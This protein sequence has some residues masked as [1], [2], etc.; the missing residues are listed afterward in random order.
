MFKTLE[1]LKIYF[2]LKIGKLKILRVAQ[3]GRGAFFV[4]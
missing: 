4:R 2:K 1:H 3:R